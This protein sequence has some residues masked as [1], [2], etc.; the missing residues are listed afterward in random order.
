[1]RG[2]S[3]YAQRSVPIAAAKPNSSTNN[4]PGT[5]RTTSGS[6]SPPSERGA[7]IGPSLHGVGVGAGVSVSRI[8]QS[9]VAA[10]TVPALVPK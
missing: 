7:R 6:N 10:K 1:M 2:Q 5:V 3:S 9:D 4:A 8:Q